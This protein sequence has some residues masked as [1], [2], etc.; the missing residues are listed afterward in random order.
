MAT[1]SFE[2]LLRIIKEEV[3]AVVREEYIEDWLSGANA[4]FDGR[5]P[6]EI[7]REDGEAGYERLHDAIEAS[8]LGI[9]R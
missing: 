1:R 9:F 8:K 3:K 2:E 5:S 4:S 7:L 6:I